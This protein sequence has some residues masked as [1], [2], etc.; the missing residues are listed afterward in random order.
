MTITICGSIKFIDQMISAQKV[1]EKA[2]HKVYMPVKA[3]ELI[4]GKKIIQ[5]E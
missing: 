5:K 3:P 2:G 4:I 1:L